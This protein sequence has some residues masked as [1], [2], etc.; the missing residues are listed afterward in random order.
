MNKVKVL[1]SY[2]EQYKSY[3]ISVLFSVFTGIFIWQIYNRQYIAIIFALLLLVSNCIITFLDY[4]STK[5]LYNC[6][7]DLN[8]EDFKKVS[9]KD[10]KKRILFIVKDLVNKYNVEK[11]NK[12]VSREGVDESFEELISLSETSYDDINKIFTSLDEISVPLNSQA[13]ELQRSSELLGKLSD[14]MDSI[15]NNFGCVQI[16]A[17][18]IKDLCTSGVDTINS[19]KEKSLLTGQMFDNIS[20]SVENFTKITKSINKFVEIITDISR[21]TKL[22]ALNASIEAAKAGDFGNGFGVVAN[23]FKKL[24]DLTKGHAVNIG[25]LM[26]DFTE[27]YRDIVKNLEGLK[28]SLNLQNDSVEGTN[29]FFKDISEAVFSITKQIDTVNNS[30]DEIKNDKNQVFKLIE[31][32]AVISE[33]TVASSEEFASIIAYHVQTVADIIECVK[34]MK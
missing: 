11:E 27:Q 19:L 8:K 6:I 31:E 14:Y 29:K 32:T 22:L 16:D 7:V 30:L 18:K 15:N 34:K 9:T 21:Q 13:E 23:N 24:S 2:I 33:E 5:K 3:F 20:K 12:V 26:T 1:I 4:M 28:N 25:D 17:F 10:Y